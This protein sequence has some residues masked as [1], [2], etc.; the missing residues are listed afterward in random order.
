MNKK[1]KYKSKDILKLIITSR[2]D[3]CQTFKAFTVIV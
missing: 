3:S 2:Y 1:S